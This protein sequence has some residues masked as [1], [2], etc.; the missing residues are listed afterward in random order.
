[1][2]SSL[3]S[4]NIFDIIVCHKIFLSSVY[5]IKHTLVVTLQ[6]TGEIAQNKIYLYNIKSW[7]HTHGEKT[8]QDARPL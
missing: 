3:E 1:M 5:I 6:S 7:R 2:A 8:F 4:K